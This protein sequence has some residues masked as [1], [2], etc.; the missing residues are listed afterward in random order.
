MA[1]RIAPVG[2]YSMRKHLD[3]DNAIE[4]YQSDDL[5]G[6]S[7][8]RNQLTIDAAFDQ[9][10]FVLFD[11]AGRVVAESVRTEGPLVSVDLSTLPKGIY[12]LHCYSGQAREVKK[13]AYF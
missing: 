12:I 4:A 3:E 1:Y 11:L 5:F 8:T 7:I 2:S 6:A 10:G 9:F 13:L